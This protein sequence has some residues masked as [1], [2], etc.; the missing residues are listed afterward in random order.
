[1]QE[2]QYVALLERLKQREELVYGNN[3]GPEVDLEDVSACSFFVGAPRFTQFAQPVQ[4]DV[5]HG[6]ESL[7]QHAHCPVLTLPARTTHVL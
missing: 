1:M 6:L 2:K 7:G 4:L 3:A 5:S